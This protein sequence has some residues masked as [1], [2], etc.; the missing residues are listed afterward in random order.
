MPLNLIVFVFGL[1]RI[2]GMS[3]NELNI[4]KLPSAKDIQN[5][6]NQRYDSLFVRNTK[7]ERSPYVCTICDEFLTTKDNNEQVALVKLKLMKEDFS[8]TAHPDPRRKTE[9]EK[10][11]TFSADRNTTGDDI[12]F[13]DGMALS[14]RGVLCKKQGRGRKSGFSCCKRCKHNIEKKKLPRHAIVNK[15]YVGAAPACLKELNEVELAFLSPVKS[16]GH[17]FTWQGGKQLKGTLTFMRVQPQKIAYAVTTLEDVGFNDHVLVL[18]TGRMTTRQKKRAKERSSI[19][20]AKVIAALEW[21]CANNYRWKDI[22]LQ[23]M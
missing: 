23:A 12:S 2:F 20:T 17:C 1:L 13:L 5:R 4:D 14:P 3:R 11:F 7:G 8:W 19:R 18:F 6:V 21:L 10:Y 16:Y 9:I 15:N 22:D